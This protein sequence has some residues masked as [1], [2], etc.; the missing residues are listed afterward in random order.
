MSTNVSDSDPNGYAVGWIRIHIVGNVD[1][2]LGGQIPTKIEKG[3]KI[4]STEVLDVLF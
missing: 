1:E 2:D 3:M 4:S